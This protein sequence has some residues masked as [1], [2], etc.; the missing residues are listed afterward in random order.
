MQYLTIVCTQPGQALYGFPFDV[1]LPN[2]V[3]TIYAAGT[4]TLATLFDKTGGALSNPFSADVN[5]LA[6]FAA[7]NGVYDIQVQSADLTYSAPL[8]ESQQLFDF[9]DITGIS[10]LSALGSTGVIA[11]G[12]VST[13]VARTIAG[14]AGKIAVT[15]GDGVA[16]NPTIGI[17]AGA[18]G[19]TELA[20]GAAAANLGYTAEN[21]ANKAADGTLAANSDTNYPTQKAV[22]TY[23][24]AAKAAATTLTV[25]GDFS[26]NLP[27]PSIAKILG[28]AL[29]NTD[30]PQQGQ[31]WVYD[32]NNSEY[33]VRSIEGLNFL[34]NPAFDIWQEATT[35]SPLS[36]SAPKTFAADGWKIGNNGSGGNGHGVFRTAGIQNSQYAMK[37]QR[38]AGTLAGGPFRLVQQLELADSMF[39]AGKTVIVSFDFTVGA[40]YSPTSGLGVSIYTGTGVDEDIDLHVATPNFATGGATQTVGVNGQVQPF[41]TVTRIVVGL[42]ITIPA[43][44]TEIAV[45]IHTGSFNGTAS[46]DDSCTIGNV[47]L[48]CGNV[49]THF[50]KP[51][52]ADE[53]ARCQRRY[54][55]S[56]RPAT[57]PA[58]NIGIG[59]G[60]ML[61]P[62][63]TAAA[64]TERLSRVIFPSPMRAV[65]A[66]T[67][68]NPAAANSHVRDEAASA[69]CSAESTQNITETGFNLTCIGNGSTAVGGYL[70][71]HYTAD[72]RL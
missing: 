1:P 55:K 41:G 5:G 63:P 35:Y 44:T 58:Q 25:G 16:G 43:G 12:G 68:Y 52:V 45:E 64:T 71:Y 60:E 8:I 2:A 36:I 39:L 32:A 56:F 47:K 53:L 59:T 10:N 51:L 24:D 72:A 48:E 4:A 15:N 66:I 6:K 7:A 61:V 38:S 37:L 46:A 3:V 70:G 42:P 28:L 65:P 14:S 67:I 21:A 62:A 19:N 69:D 17:P 29:L 20:A 22:K 23:V 9:S 31:A 30:V 13:Y 26:G 33:R 18:I 50:R 57:V 34:I 49:A 54:V 27:N 40:N 11:V